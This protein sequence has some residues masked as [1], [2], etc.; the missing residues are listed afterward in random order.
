MKV[1]YFEDLKELDIMRSVLYQDCSLDG[2]GAVPRHGL[3]PG[4]RDDCWHGGRRLVLRLS[5][6]S[7]RRRCKKRRHFKSYLFSRHFF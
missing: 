1:L 2:A 3:E 4:G 7:P 5:R 6:D